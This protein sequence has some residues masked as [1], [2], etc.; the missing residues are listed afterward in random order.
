MSQ[1]NAAYCA[2]LEPNRSGGQRLMDHYSLQICLILANS[3]PPSAAWSG[4][5]SRRRPYGRAHHSWATIPRNGQKESR[6]PPLEVQRDYR[7]RTSSAF[8]F[9]TRRRLGAPRRRS[10]KPLEP[11][12][13]SRLR[14]RR[15]CRLL[16]P[17]SS[18]ACHH[19]IFPAVARNNTS[20][21]YSSPL[22]GCSFRRRIP[23]GSV[24]RQRNSHAQALPERGTLLTGPC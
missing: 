18:A 7:L 21:G 22:K 23:S 11:C 8:A 12:S 14:Q 16:M 1:Y 10:S 19:L 17:I 5:S 13:S 24:A 9:G 3:P 15:N 2:P 20:V 6:L 4:L